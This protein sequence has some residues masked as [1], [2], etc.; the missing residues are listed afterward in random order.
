MLQVKVLILQKKKKKK[1]LLENEKFLIDWTNTIEGITLKFKVFLL[2]LVM[3][4]SRIKLLKF[5]K[6]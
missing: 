1:K 6:L 3:E 4:F 2:Q 5:L